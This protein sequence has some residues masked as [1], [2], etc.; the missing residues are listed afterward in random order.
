MRGFFLFA[1]A[2]CKTA[3]VFVFEYVWCSNI[4]MKIKYV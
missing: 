3:D 1:V 4:V 2:Y